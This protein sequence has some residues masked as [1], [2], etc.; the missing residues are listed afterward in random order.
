M[1]SCCIHPC[2]LVRQVD[3][4]EWLAEVNSGASGF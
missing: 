3:Q 1:N 4:F 2:L